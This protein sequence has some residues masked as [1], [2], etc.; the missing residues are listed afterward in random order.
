MPPCLTS[1]IQPEIGQGGDSSSE[2]NSLDVAPAACA[3]ACSRQLCRYFSR[4][5]LSWTDV[6]RRRLQQLM[7]RKMT[8]Q[9]SS[10]IN[11]LEL[12]DGASLFCVA[13]ALYLQI[14]V[15]ATQ[16]AGSNAGESN[17]SLVRLSSAPGTQ[18]IS[19]SAYSIADKAQLLALCYFFGSWR[20]SREPSIGSLRPA[21]SA[22]VLPKAVR[23]YPKI[24]LAPAGRCC[25]NWIC[26]FFCLP[27]QP[28]SV[29]T[30]IPNL[31]AATAVPISSASFS[32]S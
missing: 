17:N 32:A 10:S 20:K 1:S 26:F 7:Q 29:F 23:F 19:T 25:S 22:E 12:W 24:H 4:E 30:L 5:R 11:V 6:I 28:Y 9:N 14:V 27:F 3:L 31:H 13:K 21:V 16:P 8:V 2:A 15:A 18:P